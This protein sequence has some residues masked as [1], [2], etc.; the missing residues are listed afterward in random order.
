MKRWFCHRFI[1]FYNRFILTTVSPD[2]NAS[3]DVEALVQRIQSG[4]TVAFDELVLHFQSLVTGLLYRFTSRPADLEDLVQETF[5]K[6]WRGIPKWKPDRPF[7]HWLKKVTVNSGLEYCRKQKRSPVDL[8][9]KN[10][11]E[12]DLSTLSEPSSNQAEYQQSLEEAQHL[13]STLPPEDQSLLTL[14]YL[15]DMSLNEIA[16]HFGW[17]QSN[18]KIKAYRARNR[19][20]KTL[21][22][23]GYQFNK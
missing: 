18:A 16:E 23:H 11:D 3:L 13:L 6:I 2:S 10:G 20:K 8:S 17:S 19:L 14:L 22:K 9:H 7:E 15:Q 1:C 21:T 12:F 4:D 5:I